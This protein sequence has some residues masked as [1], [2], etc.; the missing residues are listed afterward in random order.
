VRF[1][2]WIFSRLALPPNS[3][4]HD[5]KPGV[6]FVEKDD[7]T[8]SQIRMVGL[9]IRRDNPDYYAVNVFNEA[10]AGGFSSRLFNDIRTKRGLAYHVGGGIGANYGHPGILQIVM[11]T[12]SQTTIESVQA[13]QEDIDDLEKHPLTDDELKR[14]K[15]AILNAFIFRLDSPDKILGERMTYE[16]YGYPADWLDKYPAEI[17]KVT[18]ADANRVAAK[19]LHKD[20]L[21]TLVVGND[22]EF[23]K[24]LSSLGPVKEI[25]ITIPPPPRSKEEEA[26]KPTASN[27]EG[28]ALVAKVVTA[29]GGEAKLAAIKSLKAKLTVTQKTPQGDFPM[30][31]ESVIVY[32][33]H[34]HAEIQA[35]QGTMTIVVTPDS[36]FASS[37]MGTQ[38][39]PAERKAEALEQI[40]RDPIFIASHWNDP[41]FVFQ[42]N[43]T[44][45]IGDVEARI[46]DVNAGG[47]AIRW[48][49]DPKTGQILRETY[50]TLSQQGPVQGET[51]MENW[52]TVDGITIPMLRRNKQ[53]GQDSSS[54]EYSEIEFNPSVDEKMF[55]KPADKTGPAQ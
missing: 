9:G 27:A 54:A 47:A 28:N 53:N 11:G 14:A 25:D 36:A 52:K 49:V 45:K 43:G 23:D 10:F 7:A 48:Y 20:Q 33:D 21:A 22:K 1:R 38:A 15:D 40:K 31:M 19:Y 30:Q 35:P 32:P 18:P 50:K 17:Q 4:I 55:E 34:L 2:I 5:P 41:G 6:F 51:Q 37:G 16:L 46:V 8:Q 29:M 13:L 26:P 3:R 39:M 44:E 42:A 12:K 24:P